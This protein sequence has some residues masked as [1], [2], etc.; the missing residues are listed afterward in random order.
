[1]KANIV[2]APTPD[3]SSACMALAYGMFLFLS[4][5]SF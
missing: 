1:M 2:D 4:N 5:A 3:Q